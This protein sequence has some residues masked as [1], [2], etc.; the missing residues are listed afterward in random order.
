MQSFEFWM[1]RLVVSLNERLMLHLLEME[2]YR[3]EADVPMGASQEGIA[4]RLGVQVHSV[5]RALSSLQ[6]EGLLS[7]RLAH[8]RG[9][10]KRRR[11][12]F[13]TDKGAGAARVVRADLSKRPVAVEH[14]GKA[15]EVPLEEAAKKIASVAG[16]AIPFLDL[17]DAAASSEVL[18]A[19]GFRKDRGTLPAC[20]FVQRSFGRQAVGQFFGRDKE[21]KAIVDA[22]M[23]G[24]SISVV[25]VWGMPGIGKSWLASV[26][27]EKLS[28]K[29]P[30][31]WYS[32]RDWDSDTSFLSALGAFL[33][34]QGLKGLSDALVKS[35]RP[36]DIFMPLLTDL[37]GHQIVL[38]IDDV[39]KPSL[40]VLPVLVDAV[41]ISRSAKLVMIARSVP[42][43]FSAT[44]Q[45]NY[46]I[47]LSG[48]D[49]E[50]AWDLARSIGEVS[51]ADMQAVVDQSHGHP[52]LMSLMLRGS[53][54]EAKG[55]VIGFIDREIYSKVSSEERWVLETLSVYRHPVPVDA[56]ESVDYSIIAA[57]RRKAL[58]T[59]LEE[60]VATHDLL[61]DFFLSHMRPEQRRSLHKT[62]G[63]F[64]SLRPEIEWRLETLYHYAEAQAWN[65]LKRISD[66]SA[67]ELSKYFPAETLE[68]V[69]RMPPGYGSP[70]V[71]AELAFL[72]GQLKESLGRKEEALVDF[73]ESLTLL[74][75]AGDA[76]QNGLIF[77]AVARL[78]S[79]V[80]RWTESLAAHEKALALFAR[81]GDKAGEAREWMNIGGVH[82]RRGDPRKA[83]EA[84]QKALSIASKGE[85]RAAQA[86]CLN[87]LALLD[88][89]QGH[90]RDAETK[91]KESIG[92]ANVVKDHSGGARGL[93]N[94][95]ELYRVQL[96]T[97]EMISLFLESSEAYRRA[98]E[99]VE[100]KRVL[101]ACAD[102]TADS[103][104]YE[105]AVR[106]LRKGLGDPGLRTRRGLFQRATVYDAGDLVLSSVLVDILRRSGDLKQALKE[107]Q[108]NESMAGAIGDTTSVAKAKLLVSMIHED[109]GELDLALRSLD[110]AEAILR[111]EGNLEGLV[112]VHIRAGGVEEKRGDFAAARRHYEQ[113][114]RHAETAGNRLALSIALENIKEIGPDGGP[115]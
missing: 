44:E 97:S 109:S 83:R 29:R 108:N 76:V 79:E 94:L 92:L 15:I 55:D 43:Y 93:E 39:Q 27:F 54:R 85:D 6:D 75:G 33:A 21:L 28:G 82:R 70:R 38:F 101:A 31:F 96:R 26:A 104:N 56:L 5:S 30:L 114:A 17:V 88:R 60:G 13:L 63:D 59:E 64:C 14:E 51:T 22:V 18:V 25:L 50:S 40:E 45:G 78:Q 9:A 74:G 62:A 73:Q 42:D 66:A 47:E 58:I 32:F 95:A 98:D 99:I 1:T 111:A 89:D 113:A 37:T 71:R 67:I 19:S 57:L 91:L 48:L 16:S 72:R 107:A 68:L 86:A 46:S 41:R 69:S 61:R 7:V 90:L 81:S 102:A 77:E 49:R 36:A 35:S 84:Y 20:E 23:A 80:R 24:D 106:M 8:I 110:E 12:Y 34:E 100:A 53:A 10:P 112:A 11:A 4:Q 87:N 103:S 65:D 115:G 2:R 105:G 3:E 52:M